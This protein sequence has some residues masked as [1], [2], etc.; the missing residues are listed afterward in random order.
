MYMY[1]NLICIRGWFR[2]KKTALCGGLPPPRDVTQ[3][4]SLSGGLRRLLGMFPKLRTH[5]LVS[6][7]LRESSEKIDIT[8]FSLSLR[9][10]WEK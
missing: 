8:H 9:K 1:L 10:A 6:M 4:S 7:G 3:A 2:L 5:P